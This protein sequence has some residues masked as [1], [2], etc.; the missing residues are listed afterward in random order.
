MQ[1][2]NLIVF[3]LI[4]MLILFLW[5]P[6]KHL[7]WRPPVPPPPP[8]RLPD[9]HL[10]AGLAGQLVMASPPGTTGIGPAFPQLAQVALADWSADE[11]KTWVSTWLAAKEKKPAEPQSKPAPPVVAQQLKPVKPVVRAAAQEDVVLGNADGFN[12]RVTITPDNGGGVKNLV[13]TQFQEADRLGRPV[14]NEQLHLLPNPSAHFF[15][16][17]DRAS[18][19][20]Y[21]FG[22][23]S[24]KAD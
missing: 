9:R 7:V 12:L 3:L 8:L 14:K 22:K 6:L 16:E 5:L 13:L 2:K 4:S 24:P 1:H 23:P 21:H 17:A 19:L 11:Q 20:L 10:W 18:F 15:W